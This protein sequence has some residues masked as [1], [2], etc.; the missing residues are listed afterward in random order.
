MQASNTAMVRGSPS[1]EV[2][3]RW[4]LKIWGAKQQSAKVGVLPKQNVA[5][6]NEAN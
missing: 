1:S 5:W 3:K 4:A 2:L 6:G